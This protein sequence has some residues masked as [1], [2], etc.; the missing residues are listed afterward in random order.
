ML[1]KASGQSTG[2]LNAR[3]SSRASPLPQGGS[4]ARG[5]VRGAI[6]DEPFRPFHQAPGRDHAA[7]PGDHAAGRR[8]LRFA[9]RVAAAA[10]GL[11]GDRGPGQ[12]A[13]GQPRGD[14]VDR[15]HAFGAFFRQH[16][17]GQHHEQPLQ[18]GFDPGDPAIRPGPRHQRRGAGSA[19]SH[20]RLAQPA[21]QRD[22]QHADL[23]EGQPVP[24]ADH[25]AVADL[26]C[27][28]KRPA[29]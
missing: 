25:G 3:P 11:S 26:R 15:G 4:R 24:G 27:A 14:G 12:P 8:E 21:A 7:E 22:A 2:M 10:N 19:G 16:C 28:G 20:Q 23:Q 9:A 29:L 13:R 18:P 5:L 17:R 1:A 6:T